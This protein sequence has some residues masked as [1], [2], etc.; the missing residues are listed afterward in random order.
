MLLDEQVTR[1]MWTIVSRAYADRLR[2][3]ARPDDLLVFFLSGHGVRDESTSRYYF[4]SSNARFDDVKAQRFSDCLSFEDFAA[5]ADV[6]C[7]KL[8]VLDTCH[9][10]AVQQPLRQ[11]DLK[12]ALRSLQ[13]DVVFTLTAS[14]GSQEA[15]EQKGTQLGR[16]TGRLLEALAGAADQ[17]A[18]GGDANGVVTLQEAFRYV[19]TA[20]A[21]DSAGDE[22]AQHPT[23][24]P[25]DLLDYAVVPLAGG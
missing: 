16:F 8:V 17:A 5:F 19:S 11:Q 1:P 18:A 14:E 20:V 7:R 3:E 10:G 12:A 23:V 6:P 21:A 25:I 13:S 15:V 4:V 2:D 9:S 22:H 24:G